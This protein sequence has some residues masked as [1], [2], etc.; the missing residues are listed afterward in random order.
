[1]YLSYKYCYHIV[2][3]YLYIIV[4]TESYSSVEIVVF[5]RVAIFRNNQIKIYLL[6]W[7]H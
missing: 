4:A 1:M 7:R 6:N 2:S 5:E 3:I